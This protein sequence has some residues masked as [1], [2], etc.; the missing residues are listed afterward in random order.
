MTRTRD[1]LVSMFP[2]VNAPCEVAVVTLPKLKF[3]WSK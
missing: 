2:S 3:I 1:L